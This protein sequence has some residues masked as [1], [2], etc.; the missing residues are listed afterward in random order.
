MKGES[1]ERMGVDD[2]D[3][4][5]RA[6]GGDQKAFKGLLERHYDLMYRV[7]YRFLGSRAEAEDVAQEVCLA[8][9]D[10]LVFFKGESRFETW[11]YRIVVNQCRD[12]QKRRAKL[13]KVQAAFVAETRRERRDWAD[14]E[15][16][17]R[18]LYAALDKL[19]PAYKETALLVLAEELSQA[20]VGE[21]LG[22]KEGTIAWRMNEVKKRLKEMAKHD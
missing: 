6:R 10:K 1:A 11:A 3:L 7:A 18:W 14:S 12:F 2:S 21:I 22:V 5:A 20:Q 4:A 9:A 17:V 16:R 8:L 15:A 13:W 19:E